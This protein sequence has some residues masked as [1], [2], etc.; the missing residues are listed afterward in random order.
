MKNI[1]IKLFW[2]WIGGSRGDVIKRY[3]LSSALV[4]TLLSRVEPFCAILVE[5]IM[6][7]ISVKL[8]EFGPAVQEM[9][10]KYIS[11]LQ[12]CQP[13][14]TAEQNLCAVFGRG[15]YGKLFF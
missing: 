11:Y 1:S 8:F 3:F 2:I 13:F 15:H 6:R 10:N 4:A 14:Y 9:L 12:L 5:G 7:N